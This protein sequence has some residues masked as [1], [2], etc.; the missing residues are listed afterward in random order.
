MALKKC[1][2]CGKDVSDTLD[3]CIHCGYKLNIFGDV[4]NAI[5]QAIS[6]QPSTQNQPYDII[7]NSTSIGE[8]FKKWIT[9]IIASLFALGSGY[10]LII[11]FPTI[12]H[13]LSQG[14]QVRSTVTGIRDGTVYVEVVTVGDYYLAWF[15]LVFFLTVLVI[16][17]IIAIN[18]FIGY[19]VVLCPYCNRYSNMK[20]NAQRLK[21]KYCKR[22]SVRKGDCL[23][24]VG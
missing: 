13:S 12:I 6:Q 1:P 18:S 3:Y 11:M 7:P 20:R 10:L 14:Y 24:T 9:G 22:I 2:E 4:E 17:T 19:W 8:H 16:T 5:E 15:L 23:E 21:C